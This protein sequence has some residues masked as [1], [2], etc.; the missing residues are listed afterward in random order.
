M[1]IFHRMIRRGITIDDLFEA[2]RDKFEIN[3]NR[4]WS[5]PDK[6]GIVRHVKDKK[7]INDV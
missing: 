7:V 1:M 4:T 6:D 5:K 3:K 2:I